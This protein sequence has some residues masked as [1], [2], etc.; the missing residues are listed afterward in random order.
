[1]RACS[2]IGPV[3]G[4]LGRLVHESDPR[5][6]A[7]EF[8]HHVVADGV[9]KRADALRLANAVPAQRLKDPEKGLLA[10]VVD[11]AAGILPRTQLDENQLAEVLVK[12]LFGG[13]IAGRE[14]FHDNLRQS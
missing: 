5:P 7:A 1:M 11:G 8:H 2:G 12:M 4:G 13:C 3:V 9:D 14:A 6:G 10:D